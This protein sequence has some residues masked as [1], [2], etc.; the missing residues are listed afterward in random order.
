VKEGKRFEVVYQQSVG[1]AS[2]VRILRDR[3]TGVEYLATWF[4]QAGGVTPLIGPDGL[5]VIS[6][7]Q[8]GEQNVDG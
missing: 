6:K 3:A 1:L 7:A 5:P 4:G 2:E 8:G